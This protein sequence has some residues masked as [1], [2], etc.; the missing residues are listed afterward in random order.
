MKEYQRKDFSKLLKKG[1]LEG[2]RY[3]N[4]SDS[5]AVRIYDRNIDDIPVTVELYGPY[6][7]IVDYSADGLSP[8]DE[9][10]VIDLVNRMVYVERTRIIYQK[11]HKR[12]GL[13]QHTRQS[14][15]S[16]E[17][18]VKEGG[19]S[20][21]VDLVSHIDTGLFLDQALTRDMV[22]TLSF[23]LR[24]LNLFSYT[25]SFSVYAAAGGAESVTS[26]DLSNT[27]CAVARR[28]L[29][30]NGFLDEDKYRVIREDCLSFIEG[31]I[32]GNKAYDLIIFDPPSF[33]NSHNMK[34]K[35]DVKKDYL[36][37]ICMLSKIMS[38]H[39][40]LIFS[41]NLG[42]FALDKQTLKQA[43]KVRVLTDEVK[44]PGF[45]RS[46]SGTAQVWL[47]EKTAP[48]KEIRKKTNTHAK[49]GF[50]KDMKKIEDNDF[51][52][53]INSLTS[54]SRDEEKDRQ[55]RRPYSAKPSYGR[56]REEGRDGTRYGS[57]RREDRTSG[58]YRDRSDERYGHDRYSR[59][60][61]SS[62]RNGRNERP[63]REDRAGR[64]GRRNDRDGSRGR[65]G[66]DDDYPRRRSHEGEERRPYREKR[67][68]SY[69]SRPRA[70][71]YDNI[72]RSRSRRD[73]DD[74]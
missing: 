5:T 66:R 23:G 74:E 49:G 22:R 16:L 27:Y 70:Y 51:D 28:N 37:W 34:K 56:G 36:E 47:L 24:V 18:T 61:G 12:E 8:E 26:V 57:S 59:D 1:A 4:S 19:L 53:L 14:D 60:G 15:E 71:G 45:T 29:Q 67:Q 72:R 2:R 48:M 73:E 44:A 46:G 38:D 69:R 7:K 25:G 17:L 54:E 58:R 52:A 39:A 6:A 68:D 63:Y 55:E 42:N 30:A 21:L 10:T 31:E 41:C 35:F 43:F 9:E 32:A 13:E 33:S 11:R 40:L 3:L 64:Y 50:R 20:F 62:Y 65:E